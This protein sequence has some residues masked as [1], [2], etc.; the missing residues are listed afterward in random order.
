MFGFAEFARQA[1]IWRAN[2]DRRAL[3]NVLSGLPIELR[4]DIG[5]PTPEARNTPAGAARR[6]ADGLHA[7]PIV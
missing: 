7:R 3:H 2:R 1:R 4:K 6:G 5:W